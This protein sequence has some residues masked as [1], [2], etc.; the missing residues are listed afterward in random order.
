M[1]DTERRISPWWVLVLLP[2][3][4][5]AGWLVGTMPVPKLEAPA[6]ALAPTPAR[7]AATV[8]VTTTETHHIQVSVA[9]P[10]EIHGSTSSP[11]VAAAPEPARPSAPSGELSQWTTY[12]NALD[13]SRRNGKPILIDFNASW[14]GPCQAL[15]REVFDDA[16]HGHAVE[17]AVIPVSIV[18][19]VREEGRNP[20]DIEELQQRFGVDAFPTLVILNPASGRVMKTRGFGGA[21]RMMAWIAS[22]VDAVR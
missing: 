6:T 9:S 3:A 10:T 17:T 7:V 16:V 11:P 19:R 15:R 21:D 22:A 13:E 5:A 20:G 12:A 18:D 8:P 2:L 4:P 14:C 1:A